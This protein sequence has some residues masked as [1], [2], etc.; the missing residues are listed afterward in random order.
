VRADRPAPDRPS[1]DSRSA[2]AG[3]EAVSDG[4]VRT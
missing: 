2:P 1:Q 3:D 4:P